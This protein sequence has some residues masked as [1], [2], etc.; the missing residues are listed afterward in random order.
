VLQL[1]PEQQFQTYLL[2]GPDQVEVRLTP[3]LKQ[4]LLRMTSTDRPG[5]YRVQ[6]GGTSGGVDRGLSVNAAAQQTQL[7]RITDEQ[8]KEL[9]GPLPCRVARSRDQ[10]DRDVSMGRVGRELF[11]LLIALVAVVLGLE[12]VLANRFYKE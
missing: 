1:D 6:A 8:L 7:D 3:D 9:F 2:T 11:P 12:H 10:I 5:N 4:N